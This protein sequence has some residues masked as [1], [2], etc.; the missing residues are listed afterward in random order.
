MVNRD[1]PEF[2][3]DPGIHF[4]CNKKDIIKYIRNGR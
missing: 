3:V 4:I 2:V 1:L